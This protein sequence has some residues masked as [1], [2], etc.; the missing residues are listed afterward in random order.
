[1]SIKAIAKP[2]KSPSGKK[3]LLAPG[4]R[5]CAGCGQLIAARAVAEAL[6]PNTIIA[7]ATG[8][9]EVTTT[10]YPESAWGMPWIHSLFENPAAIAS[11]IL[12]ALKY[13]EAKPLRLQSNRRGLAS[14]KVVAQGGDGSTFDIGF[15]LISGMWERGENILY[16]CYDNEA[17]MNTG[18]QA[19][20]ATP[21]AANTTTSPTGNKSFGSQQRKKDMITIALAHRVPYVAQTTVGFLA[22]IANKIKKAISIKGPAYLQILSPCIPGWKINPS[23][24]IKIGKLAAQTGCYPIIEYTN[25]QLTNV[26][27]TS[28]TRPKVDEYLKLQGRFKH[29]FSTK[30]GEKQIEHI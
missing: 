15:G 25:G 19:S 18:I 29:L 12:A 23:Q 16:I 24:T 28:Q 30:K 5:A 4:H 8:C 1:M 7:N 22:D 9:L 3:P 2:K 13:K 10:P 11:G 14:P 20:G 26:M 21:W 6:G 27:E 17:Y